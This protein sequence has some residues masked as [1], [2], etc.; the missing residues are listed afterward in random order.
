MP[1]DKNN[2]RVDWKYEIEIKHLIDDEAD[3]ND[4][5]NAIDVGK[6]IANRLKGYKLFEDSIFITRFE[7]DVDTV[8]DLNHYLDELYDYCDEEL[9]WVK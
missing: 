2:K 5:D 9:I 6:Q 8:D 1:Y 3:P 7:Q 4:D